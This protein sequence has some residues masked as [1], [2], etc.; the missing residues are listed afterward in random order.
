MPP[1]GSSGTKHPSGFRSTGAPEE[2]FRVLLGTD[3]PS[4]RSR[5]EVVEDGAPEGGRSSRPHARRRRP[6]PKIDKHAR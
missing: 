3:H 5:V 1:Q 2:P 6:V 4:R